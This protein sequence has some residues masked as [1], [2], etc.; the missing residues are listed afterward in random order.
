MALPPRERDARQSELDP[1]LSARHSDLWCAFMTVS[2]LQHRSIELKRSNVTPEGTL[3]GYGAVFGNLDSYGDTIAKGAFTKS[4]KDWGARKKLPLM[5]LQHGGGWS[6]TA[7][8][9]IPIGQWT[10]MKQDDNGLQVEGRLF[11]LDTDK[12]RYI[13]EGLKAGVLDGL[14]IG[15][16]AVSATNGSGKKGEPYRTLTE[17]KLYEVSVVSFPANDLARVEEAKAAATFET[18]RDLEQALRSGVR[19]SRSQAARIASVA[20]KALSVNSTSDAGQRAIEL[21]RQST[22]ALNKPLR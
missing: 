18:V 4:L 12:G 9:G 3:S 7:E 1:D 22:A 5:L 8:D 17:V 21:L 6:G 14:S 2:Q 19:F 10:S 16:V 13:H 20:H 15:Y 11:A